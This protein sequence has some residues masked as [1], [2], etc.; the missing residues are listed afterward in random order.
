MR[1]IRLRTADAE[2][3]TKEI[4]VLPHAH[5]VIRPEHVG[6]VSDKSLDLLRLL[7]AVAAGDRGRAAGGTCQT[8]QDLDRRGLARPVRTDQAQ[9]LTTVHGQREMIERGELSILL[10]QVLRSLQRSCH[11]YHSP[12]TVPATSSC[13]DSI[14]QGASDI[15]SKGSAASSLPTRT[16]NSSP[17]AGSSLSKSGRSTTTE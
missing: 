3:G 12:C 7:H 15:R 8:D 17:P 16:T 9:D 2:G 1:W 14:F 10:G 5:V 13:N 4:E 11:S 6:H